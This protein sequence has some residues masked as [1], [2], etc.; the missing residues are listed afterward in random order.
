MKE[1]SL[2]GYEVGDDVCV[3]GYCFSC[4]VPVDTVAMQV[5]EY[6]RQGWTQQQIDE[7]PLFAILTMPCGERYEFT[8]ETFPRVTTPCRCGNPKHFVMEVVRHE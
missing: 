8:K 6:L 5:D 4:N 2:N 1:L 3:T 7:A